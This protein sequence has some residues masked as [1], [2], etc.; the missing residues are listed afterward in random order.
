MYKIRQ[1]RVKVPKCP[2]L[3]TDFDKRAAFLADVV[4]ISNHSDLLVT[5]NIG[6]LKVNAV[7]HSVISCALR[8]DV[9][10]NA[11]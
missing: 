4:N 8:S 7:L 5:G 6:G 10:G 9:T 11:S 2:W 1:R 3:E